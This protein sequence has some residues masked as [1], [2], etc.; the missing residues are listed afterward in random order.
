[1]LYTAL[2]KWADELIMG[3]SQ[4]ISRLIDGLISPFAIQT[5]SRQYGIFIGGTGMHMFGLGNVER[6]YNMYDGT[7]FY[8]GGVGNPA[9]YESKNRGFADNG[10]GYGWTK[11][12]DRIEA[13]VLSHYRGW[14]KLHVF[15]WSRGAAMGIEFARR[16]GRY[17]I[18]VEFLGLFDPVYSYFLPGQ[19]SSLI[20]WSPQGRQ[21]NYVSAIPTTNVKAIGALYAIHEDRSF[22]PATRLTQDGITRMKLMKSPGAHGEIGGHFLSD[23]SLQRMNLRSMVEFAMLDGNVRIAFR[24]IEQ[25][26]VQIFSSPVTKKLQTQAIVGPVTRIEGR[27]KAFAASELS[28]WQAMRA[29]EYY[30]ELIEC[31]VQRWK[32]SGYG[33]QKGSWTGAIAFGLEWGHEVFPS[34][35]LPSRQS[36]GP[37]RQTPYSHYRRELDW[38]ELELWD[39]E[40]MQD[41]SGRNRLTE[42]QKDRVRFFY[43]LK[44]DP[45]TGGWLF[46]GR[47]VDSFDAIP[48]RDAI[49]SRDPRGGH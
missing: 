49:S 32:P 17:G 10:A 13:D 12:L 16:M 40:F 34:S 9:E 6:L 8:Y 35:I 36:L 2:V 37:I 48:S 5:E 21:G 44:V 26:L 14:Q 27:G 25:D 39:L 47:P 20:Q 33:F 1:M 15:G 46:N 31:S 28:S 3:S 19:S 29:E 18:E 45:R 30:R 41:A 43:Q 7:K 11:I 42:R 24:G 4:E 22:F 23:L 38:C